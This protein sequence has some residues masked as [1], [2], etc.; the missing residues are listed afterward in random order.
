[1]SSQLWA[2][3]P[4]KEPTQKLS[5]KDTGHHCVHLLNKQFAEGFPPS[6]HCPGSL[7]AIKNPRPSGGFIPAIKISG[8]YTGEVGLPRWLSS[9]E[10]TY[11]RCRRWWFDPWAAK[12]P[13]KRKWQLTPVFLP[14]K[15]HGQRSL[16]MS[17]YSDGVTQVGHDRSDRACAQARGQ[18]ALWGSRR[19]KEG[20]TGRRGV[21]VESVILWLKC[22][23]G[24]LS[25]WQSC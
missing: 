9:K 7:R 14:G 18:W 19:G 17:G 2:W 24:L 22:I 23:F 12:L 21:A 20:V 5:E 3:G 10:S 8:R 25:L 4:T 13:W 6:K 1:M 16:S 15:R 11:R